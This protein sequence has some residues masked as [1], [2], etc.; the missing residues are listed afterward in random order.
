MQ[1]LPPSP[2]FTLILA[3][4]MNMDTLGISDQGSVPPAVYG[5]GQIRDAVSS[6]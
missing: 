3:S 1:P 4:S 2:A 5:R 6:V